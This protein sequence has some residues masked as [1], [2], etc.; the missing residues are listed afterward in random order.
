MDNSL[1]D[2]KFYFIV[3]GVTYEIAEP[4]GFDGAQFV[5]EQEEGRY[6][7]DVF[8]SDTDFEFS[9]NVE[10]KGLTH[11]FDILVSQYK[12]KGF[13]ADV[14]LAIEVNDVRYVLGQLDFSN[15]DT[16]L[17]QY[18]KFKVIQDTNQAKVKRRT[19]TTID[20]YKAIGFD[21]EHIEKHKILLEPIPISQQSTWEADQARQILYGSTGPSFEIFWANFSVLTKFDIED[22]FSPV[23]GVAS[24]STDNASDILMIEAANALGGLEIKI[25]NLDFRLYAIDGGGTGY[26]YAGMYWRKG[27]VFAD[28]DINTIFQSPHLVE[29]PDE[30]IQT[31]DFTI[32][33]ISLERDEKLWIYFFL[34]VY[35][36]SLVQLYGQNYVGTCDIEI[37]TISTSIASTVNGVRLFDAVERTVKSIS[38]K[39]T[40]SPR[41]DEEGEFYDQFLFTGNELRGISEKFTISL[42]KIIEWFP[43]C[44]LD[45]EVL[46]NGDIFVGHESDFY[47][48]NLIKS[49]PASVL[50][51]YRSYFNEK[52][53][54]N[55]LTYKYKD[56]E[57]G[58][59][60]LQKDSLQ[61]VNTELEMTFPNKMVENSK[62]I[63]VEFARDAFLI[64]K[65]R[66]DGIIVT[67][68]ASTE[69]DDEIFILDTVPTE[70]GFEIT[71]K[72]VLRHI[73]VDDPLIKVKLINDGSF[74]W[75]LLGF[76]LFDIIELITP[77]GGTY[78]VGNVTPAVLTLQAIPPTVPDFSG[79]VFTEMTY[80]PDNLFLKNRKGEGFTYQEG[81]TDY[82]SNLKYAPKRNLLKYWSAYLRTV[83]HYNSN[84]VVENADYRNGGNVVAWF[85]DEMSYTQG[86]QDRDID[87]NL[88]VTQILTPEIV[89]A[90]VLCSFADFMDIQSKVRGSIPNQRGY[91]E[92]ERTDGTLVKLHPK[93]LLYSWNEL[94]MTITGE[95]RKN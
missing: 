65:T 89:E 56:Y 48:D 51:G 76:E 62:D 13:E 64:E 79:L 8:F 90:E 60:E 22:S 66:K 83:L 38:G 58:K 34:G 88:Y 84:K 10:I 3:S 35:P 7:R 25:T 32:S 6:G 12:S 55:R 61:G 57:Q 78:I 42:E 81:L 29:E 24:T 46:A 87:T 63:E 1:R 11:K 21:S 31:G 45:Y 36:Q 2:T 74:N 93:R 37:N 41:L 92:V 43:E 30:Y 44:N 70:E 75:E 91:V 18:F 73:V 95:V 19:D 53:Q 26:T 77:N 39:N 5:L 72:L 86:R 9:P 67:E 85:G 50:Q 20:L 82:I 27:A 49:F 4:I 17:Y 16:D 80:Q 54:A 52:F 14:K 94:K 68:D 69:D 71:L 40:I 15:C 33:N 28:A 47:T 23:P 59:N